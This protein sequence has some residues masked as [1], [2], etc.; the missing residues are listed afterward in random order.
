MP[1]RGVEEI[2]KNSTYFSYPP[3]IPGK[4]FIP[5]QNF[6][7]VFRTPPSPVHKVEIL[8]SDREMRYDTTNNSSFFHFLTFFIV[9]NLQIGNAGDFL[10]FAIKTCGHTGLTVIL[11]LE[12]LTFHSH[13]AR[14]KTVPSETF[15]SAP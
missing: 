10:P 12:N 5:P 9:I 15:T 13:T 3:K 1:G 4:Y 11:V 2:S 8:T 6:A 7:E 14:N